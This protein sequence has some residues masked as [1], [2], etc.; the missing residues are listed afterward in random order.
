MSYLGLLPIALVLVAASA[1]CLSYVIAVIRGDVSA[2]FPYISD[3]GAEVP[4]SCVFGQLLNIGAF[5]AF[6]T[7]YVRF[8]A[9]QAIA[10]DE[11]RWLR[12]MNKA[13]MLLGISSAFGCSLVANFQESTV[14]EMVHVIGAA[15]TFIGGLI[16]CVMHTAMSYHMFP[17]YN[18]LLICRVRLTITLVALVCL[19]VTIVSAAV[20]I[21]DWSDF[22]LP[23]KNKFKWGPDEPGYAAHVVSTVGEWLTALTFLGFFFTYV[24]ELHKFDLE[25]RI[26]PLVRH[27]DEEPVDGLPNE[28]S[29]LL[30]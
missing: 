19:A 6:S 25:V 3:S 18:G 17:N 1:F 4:E 11:D 8:K 23:D 9:I 29:P 14:V 12:R 15:L 7:M 13:T 5:L 2:A 26:R 27:L 30:D 16:Y 20:A 24:R 22:H 28:R 10:G 21:Q